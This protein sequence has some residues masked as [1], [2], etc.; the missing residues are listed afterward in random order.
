M[1]DAQ[2]CVPHAPKDLTGPEVSNAPARAACAR[3]GAPLPR[4]KAGRVKAGIRFCRE[5]CRLA[6][7][8]ERRT[9]ARAEL[10]RALHQIREQLDRAEDALAILGLMPAE[11]RHGGP[12]GR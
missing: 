4:T 3:C 1:S 8:R 6:D 9:A 2:K 11:Q 10:A 5:A 7:V 12:G